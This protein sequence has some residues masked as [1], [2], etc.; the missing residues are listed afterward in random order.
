MPS[1]TSATGPPPLFF[2]FRRRPLYVRV[3]LIIIIYQLP[4]ETITDGREIVIW[5][6]LDFGHTPNNSLRRS[7]NKRHPVLSPRP[8]DASAHTRD[9]WTHTP[10]ILLLLLL[11]LSSFP[12]SRRINPF[13]LFIPNTHTHTHTHSEPD[14]SL[15]CSRDL[16]RVDNYYYSVKGRRVRFPVSAL[17]RRRRTIRK[18]I[19]LS[20][21][22]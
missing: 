18:S 2:A 4:P 8:A 7:R 13:D 5:V 15:C 1:S 11:L 20:K 22:S 10:M 21:K 6:L 12:S 16:K 17:P 19:F 3:V 9:F 14:R